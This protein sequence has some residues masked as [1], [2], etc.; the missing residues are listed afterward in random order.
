MDVV[1]HA[2]NSFIWEAEAGV[3]VFVGLVYKVSPRIAIAVT[4]RN[5][6]SEKTKQKKQ[7]PTKQTNKQQTHLR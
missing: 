7:K 3:W 2:L 4:H 6:V 1:A 5:F